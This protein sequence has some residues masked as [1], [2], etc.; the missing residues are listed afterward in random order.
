MHEL[1]YVYH[2]GAANLRTRHSS[3]VGVLMTDISNPSF[4][5]LMLGIEERLGAAG[6][7]TMFS[8]TFDDPERELELLRSLMEHPVDAIVY[9]PVTEESPQITELLAVSAVP[10]LAVQRQPANGPAYLG[11]DNVLGGRLAAEHLMRVHGCRR[12]VF[13][14]G[15]KLGSARRDR[16]EGVRTTVDADPD[17]ELVYESEGP[18]TVETARRMAE[19][20]IR[21]GTSFDGVVCHSDLVAYAFTRAWRDAGQTHLVPVIGFDDLPISALFEPTIS[22]VTVG[23]MGARA[24]ERV[25]EMVNGATATIELM[26]PTLEIRASCGCG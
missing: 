18:T 23:P 5:K 9:V 1:G 12:L 10:V 19:A 11:P 20:A 21:S 16:L 22:S 17:A 6:Y 26:T 25:I 14:G 7:F 13:L 4:A 8:N 24:A 3:I 2:R 15:P